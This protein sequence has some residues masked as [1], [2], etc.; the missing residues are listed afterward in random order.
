[1]EKGTGEQCVEFITTKSFLGWVGER[2]GGGKTGE[3]V[4]LYFF[5]SRLF[6]NWCCWSSSPRMRFV[7]GMY[8]EDLVFIFL[9]EATRTSALGVLETESVF[10]TARRALLTPQ[11]C[12]NPRRRSNLSGWS[13]SHRGFKSKRRYRNGTEPCGK[14]KITFSNF[15]RISPPSFFYPCTYFFLQA[16]TPFSL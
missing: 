11:S 1:M 8:E 12:Q 14:L 15:S 13:S 2:E 9:C 10:L 5:L 6:R 3:V 4:G 16:P 7:S